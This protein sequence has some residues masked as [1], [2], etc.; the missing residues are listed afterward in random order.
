M[1]RQYIPIEY[2]LLKVKEFKDFIKSAAFMTYLVMRS[3]VWRSHKS[4]PFRLRELYQNGLLCCVFNTRNLS[5]ACEVITERTALNH[6]TQLE[7]KFRVIA[8]IKF[9]TPE[10]EL[11]EI[12]SWVGCKI[13]KPDT[14][15]Y[16]LYILGKWQ[17]VKVGEDLQYVEMW[18]M[19]RFMSDLMEIQKENDLREEA[20]QSS[21]KSCGEGRKNFLRG[22]KKLSE[23]P[24]KS[25]RGVGKNFPTINKEHYKYIKEEEVEEVYDPD[26]KKLHEIFFQVFKV[27]PSGFQVDELM[28]FADKHEMELEVILEALRETGRNNARTAKYTLRILEDWKKRR[29]RTLGDAKKA[30]QAFKDQ[31][32]SK[33]NPKSKKPQK[34][35]WQ[36][37]INFEQFRE[38]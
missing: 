28:D 3:K 5:E 27:E 1:S 18:L 4:N 2:E 7:K 14:P 24:E 38:N 22:Q 15:N 35:K 25:F 26:V 29:I 19:N 16:T 10:N 23:G 12:E 31:T 11:L 13:P 8:S 21:E 34:P 36:S 20:E 17:Y 32:S 6:L 33:K 30:L 37:N 9:D